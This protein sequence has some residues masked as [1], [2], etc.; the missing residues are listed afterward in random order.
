MDLSILNVFIIEKKTKWLCS[1][2][3]KLTLKA[4]LLTCHMYFS[5]WIAPLFFWFFARSKVFTKVTTGFS[6]QNIF[7]GNPAKLVKNEYFYNFCKI[8][9]LLLILEAALEFQHFLPRQIKCRDNYM[10]Y[11]FPQHFI[12]DVFAEGGR[13]YIKSLGIYIGNLGKNIDVK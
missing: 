11:I 8:L 13:I 2:W 12:G 1:I 4:S 5:A 9:L 6:V 7:S 3:S 10:K